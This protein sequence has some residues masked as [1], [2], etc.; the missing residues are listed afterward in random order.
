MMGEI[1][2]DQIRYNCDRNRLTHAL[3]SR[4]DVKV[5]TCMHDV[6]C[7][8]A[9]LLCSDGFWELVWEYEML[10]DLREASCAEQWLG[11]MRRRVESRLRNDSDNNTAAAIMIPR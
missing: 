5:D 9:F 2:A 10:A 3:G 7:G 8:D 11:A 1:T 4:V 6:R